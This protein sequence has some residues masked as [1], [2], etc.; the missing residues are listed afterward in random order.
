[1]KNWKKIVVLFALM[2]VGL[3]I[4]A[5]K[6]EGGLLGGI[7]LSQVDG[8]QNGGY[9]KFGLNGGVFVHYLTDKNYGFGFDLLYN[10]KGSRNASDEQ[11]L[12]PIWIYHY[13][14]VELPIYYLYLKNKWS[15][16]GGLNWAYVFNSKF[17]DGGSPKEI[18]GLRNT[19]VLFQLGAYYKFN[20]KMSAFLGHQYSIRSII[21]TD[22]SSINIPLQ[23]FRRNGVYHN[24]IQFSLHYYLTN[25]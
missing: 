16:R 7:N 5:Q 14:Y 2:H 17:D 20:D 8:D 3:Y 1:M 10:N 21:D 12:N 19:D 22:R 23:Q 24:L 25:E 18:I 11:N 13:H 15:F 6:F 4:H 9:N